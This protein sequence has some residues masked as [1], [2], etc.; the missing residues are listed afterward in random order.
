[1]SLHPVVQ[2][3][4]LVHPFSF[5]LLLINSKML[6]LRR[7]SNTRLLSSLTPPLLAS[8]STSQQPETVD[9]GYKEVPRNAKQ[10][11]VKEVF[12]SVSSNYDVMND[13]MSVGLHRCW[14]NYFVNKLGLLK[15]RVEI[16]PDGTHKYLPLQILDVAGGTGDISL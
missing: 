16:Q 11:L 8:F 3:L 12:D 4:D 10:S 15:A 13:A 7:L 1:M 2:K 14:K 9:F 5:D 6:H